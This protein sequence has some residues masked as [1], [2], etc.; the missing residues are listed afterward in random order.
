MPNL[1]AF[2]GAAALIALGAALA[3]EPAAAGKL[4]VLYHSSPLD[5]DTG[6]ALYQPVPVGNGAVIV[7][8]QG[9]A[10]TYG[11]VLLLTPAAAGKPYARTVLHTFTGQCPGDGGNP[12]GHLV[13]DASGNI[14][15]LAN[16]TCDTSGGTLFELVKPA[17]G[18][19][20]TFR[21]ALQMPTSYDCGIFGSGYD[22]MVFSPAGSLIGLY[23]S[24]CSASNGTI[25][26]VPAA[27]LAGHSQHVNLLYSF[28]GG[29]GVP[30]GLVRD[31]HGNLFGIQT[32]GGS[33]QMG[34][35]WEVSPPA[36]SGAAWTGSVIHSFCAVPDQYNDCPDGY[37][38]LGAPAVGHDGT[39]YGTSE[40]EGPGPAGG[41]GVVWQLNAGA[42]GSSWTLTDLTVFATPSG[43]QFPLNDTLL[44]H[45]GDVITEMTYGGYVGPVG[46]QQLAQGA[47][48]AI[49]PKTDAVRYISQAFAAFQTRSGPYTPHSNLSMDASGNLYGSTSSYYKAANGGSVS[50]GVI[51]EITN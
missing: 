6:N 36:S 35:V 4:T 12:S 37:N 24:G 28:P 14:W 48:V 29:S 25:V 13:P 2:R 5:G 39:L 43:L 8:A 34:A 38:P 10:G 41:A 15:G 16:A 50:S 51:F 46:N 40:V 42:P 45:G 44:S 23:R 22:D 19:S 9:G 32:S 17:A 7:E 18:G 33:A 11:L 26:E 3:A 31:S 21:V 47:V 30:T 49:N 1:Q 20:W 27:S